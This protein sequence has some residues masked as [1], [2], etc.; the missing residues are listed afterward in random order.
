MSLLSFKLLVDTSEDVEAVKGDTELSKGII[1][2]ACEAPKGH[3]RELSAETVI[4]I[5]GDEMIFVNGYQTWTHS[6]EFSVTDVQKTYGKKLP[7]ALKN[8][9]HL[10]SYGDLFFQKYSG[11]PGVFIGYSYCYIRKGEAF[12]LFASLDEE[13]GYTVF[14]VDAASGRLH[15][16]R[17]CRGVKCGGDLKAF[18]LFYAEGAEDEVFD[19]WFSAMELKPRT[20]E[21]LAGYTSWYNR[22]NKIDE[23]CLLSD[24][25]G[26]EK[27]LKKGDLFQIDDGW[28]TA[29]G[30]WL[31]VREDRFPSG[32]RAFTDK[33]HGKGFKAGL[34][35][36][37]FGA[38]ES[39]ELYKKHPDWVLRPGGKPW[40]A[41]VNW[42]PFYGLD[43]DNA[44][45]VEYLEKVFRT[46]TQ[47]WNFDF[48]KLD[49][50]YA[51][52]PYGT[53][54]ESRAGRMIRAMKLL[55]R[56]CGDKLMLGCGVPL[57]PAFG[58]ADYCRIGCDVGPDWDS[59]ALMRMT[60]RERVSTK[61]SID[62]TTFRR[63]LNGRAFMNDPD[64][65]FLRDENCKLTEEEK[66]LLY[67]ANASYGGLLLTSDD[68]NKWDGAKKET[69]KNI[70]EM[71]GA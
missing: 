47:D 54:E 70:R 69:Y 35:L 39:S 55:R 48:V 13:P 1:R 32:L 8:R 28:Q 59:T 21:K 64:V 46:V 52:A 17:D 51:A 22:Y 9:F 19:A 15:I 10:D 61:N 68:M 20:S 43:I 56:I 50:L 40:C 11:K 4:D 14:T 27:V 26:A 49:F 30:D 24:L 16:S 57:M 12:R 58:L 23:K 66:K 29:V 63:Q 41:G 45:F 44:Q 2:I 34:W 36:A 53:E 6:P 3:I 65:F 7:G 31:S 67:T 62:D 25:E 37:P 38:Q 33:I 42:G 5:D 71:F 60:H 18:E